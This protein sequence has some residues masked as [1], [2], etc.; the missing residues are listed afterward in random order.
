MR[1]YALT[2]MRIV[3]HY[4]LRRTRMSALQ[5]DALPHG[6]ATAPLAT[7]EPPIGDT[8][9]TAQFARPFYFHHSGLLP[10][11]SLPRRRNPCV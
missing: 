8:K 1:M 10:N 3:S 11:S 9:M 4:A 7:A 5:L 6:R 2:H